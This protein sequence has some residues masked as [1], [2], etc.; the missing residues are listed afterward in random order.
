MKYFFLAGHVQYARYLTHYL[1]EMQSE[2]KAD[3]VCRHHNGYWNA[4][5]ADQFGEQTA[6]KIGKGALKGMTL[7]AELVSE[8]IDAFP[9]TVHVTNRMDYIYSDTPDQSKQEKHKE[10]LKHRRILDAHDRS[11]IDAEVEKYPHPLEDSRPHL[12]NPVTGLIAP[13]DVNVANS[14]VIGEKMQSKY[15]ASLPDGFYNPISS[16]IKT[17]YALKKK[18]KGNVRPVID[19]ENIFLRLL[20]IGQKRQMELGPL[21]AYELC[22][23]PSSLIDEHGCLRKSNKSGLVKR[24]GVLETLPIAPEILIVDVSQLFYHMVV[25]QI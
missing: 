14:M 16:P 15:I 9:I 10:E 7:S 24:L 22:A 12:Y 20:M 19:L 21:F 23:V 25:P 4:V 13:D 3:I 18:T 5:S 17:M 6:I 8:W 11:L 2:S 1:L